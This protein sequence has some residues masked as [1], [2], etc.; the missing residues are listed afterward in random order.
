MKVSQQWQAINEKQF[1]N[2]L[3]NDYKSHTSGAI[4]TEKVR[5]TVTLSADEMAWL[6]R[7]RSDNSYYYPTLESA[8]EALL[9]RIANEPMKKYLPK[10]YNKIPKS[11]KHEESFT[12]YIPKTLKERLTNPNGRRVLEV[13]RRLRFMIANSLQL[14]LHDYFAPL[15]KRKPKNPTRKEVI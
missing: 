4:S 14:S 8:T 9:T 1:W 11:M 3:P 15:T 2:S 6:R 12:M 10:D 7:F 13:S 5:V